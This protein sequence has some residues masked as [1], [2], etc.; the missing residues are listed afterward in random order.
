MQSLG[1]E[2]SSYGVAT[3][4]KDLLDYIIID[5]SDTNEERIKELGIEVLKTNISLKTIDDRI[6]LA[7]FILEKFM[8]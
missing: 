8:N 3:I 2:V 5:E 1:I 7:K 4:Y 6:R